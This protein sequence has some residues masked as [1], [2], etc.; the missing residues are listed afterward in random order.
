MLA[1]G[2]SR[3]ERSGD[4]W[5]LPGAKLELEEFEGLI[6]QIQIDESSHGQSYLVVAGNGIHI[7]LSRKAY[8]ILAGLSKG[9]SAADLAEVLSREHEIP[10]T[11]SDVEAVGGELFDRLRTIAEKRGDL[12]PRW[13]W[14]RLRLVPSRIVQR[15]AGSLSF[16]FQRWLVV[17]FVVCI[18]VGLGGAA[19]HGLAFDTA[20]RAFLPGYGLFLLS[21]L[22]HELGH[23]SAVAR[24]G[25]KPSDIGFT[26]YLIYPA[27]YSDVT[28]T[29]RL[30]RWQRVVVDLGG[31]YFQFAVGTLYAAIYAL[32]GEGAFWAAYLMIFYGSL[33]SLNPIFKF[34]GYW[35]VA[36]LLGVTNLEDQPR[37]LSK[38]W[39]GWIRGR[40]GLKLPWPTWVAIAL[41]AY[42]VLAFVVWG[43]FLTLLFPHLIRQISSLPG[44]LS[45]LLEAAIQSPRQSLWRIVKEILQS[46][47]MLLFTLFVLSRI[48]GRLFGPLVAPF[49]RLIHRDEDH[50]HS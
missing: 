27:F 25:A 3:V 26:M 44:L 45:S 39:L 28:A 10:V 41:T 36:D 17:A 2:I 33:F 5:N 14:L 29:W 42:G 34:D 15:I 35:L 46:V 9:E 7:K 38:F 22:F 11:A 50:G 12:L 24:Y 8:L 37:R 30:Q 13:F 31:M 19:I 48:I 40:A 43:F 18:A 20:E 21:L 23:A 49:L 47:L 1:E 16:L 4:G 6:D 32:T